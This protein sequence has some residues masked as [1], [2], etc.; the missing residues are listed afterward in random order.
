[1]FRLMRNILPAAV[2]LALPI[3]VWS[4]CPSGTPQIENQTAGGCYSSIQ[5]AVNSA[6]SGDT[7]VA[8]PGSYNENVE[9]DKAGLKL[10]SSGGPS[11]TF[12]QR[13]T[14]KSPII[15]VSA[16]NVTIGGFGLGF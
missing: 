14:D 16:Y 7:L 8:S 4:I 3:N 10:R 5:A 2:W 6:H 13:V 11:V 12:V 15:T 9:I 1:M